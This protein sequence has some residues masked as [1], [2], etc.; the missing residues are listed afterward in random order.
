LSE[1]FVEIPNR[2][3]PIEKILD[4]VLFT[5]LELSSFLTSE[6][7]ILPSFKTQQ[8]RWQKVQKGTQKVSEKNMG[9]LSL[10]TPK[11]LVK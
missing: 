2:A 4:D 8:I 3:Y 6:M 10:W 1:I 7:G 5:N 11:R 9:A